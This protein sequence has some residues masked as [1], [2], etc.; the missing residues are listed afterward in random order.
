MTA[1]HVTPF[2]LFKSFVDFLDFY[3]KL[4]A[5]IAFGAMD[6]AAR[7]I[8]TTNGAA[9]VDAL[10]AKAPD[11]VSPANITSPSKRSTSHQ[12]NRRQK[13]SA[14]KRKTS[15]RTTGRRKAA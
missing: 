4:G 8:P 10:Q 15:K 9:I 11:V 12:S 2:E 5:T 7:M 3:P 13:T 14:H 6:A 1:N